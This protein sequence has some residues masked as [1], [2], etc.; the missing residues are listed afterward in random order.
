MEEFG[1]RVTKRPVVF[2]KDDVLV[3]Y[4][5]KDNEMPS[6]R[7]LY[8]KY[9][10]QIASERQLDELR[11]NGKPGFILKETNSKGD[12]IYK[13]AE[14]TYNTRFLNSKIGA[15]LCAASLTECEK[16]TP[17]LCSKVHDAE[18]KL[19]LYPFITKGYESFNTSF[20]SFVVMQC[21]NYCAEDVKLVKGKR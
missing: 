2:L 9:P 3:E 7:T 8:R 11:K 14:I 15:H 1:K 4:H 19:E 12:A 20:D 13:Y 18:K 16:L 21:S 17:V 6:E 10:L 5:V